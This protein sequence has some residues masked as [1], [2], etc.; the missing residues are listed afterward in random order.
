MGSQEPV[1]GHQER[2]DLDDRLDAVTAQ[3]EPGVERPREQLIW[4][5]AI[6][7]RACRTMG[8][9]LYTNLL[10]RALADLED[11]GPTWR[12]VRP[13]VAPGRGHAIALRLLAAVHRLVL[14]SEAPHLEPFYASAGGQADPTAAWPAV[15]ALLEDREHDLAPLVALACQTND[16]GRASLLAIG[17]LD[18]A[19]RTGQPIALTEIGTAAGLNLRWDRFH[20]AGGGQRWGDPD[21][22]GDL[23]GFWVDVPAIGDVQATVISRR[24]VDRSPID[25]TTEEGELALTSSVWG[26]QAARF[27]RLRGAIDLA[28]TEPA[29]LVTADAVGWV[30]NNLAPI[31]GQ[32]T[33]LAQS[34]LRE[35]LDADS[36]RR[37]DAAVAAAGARATVTAPLAWVQL[38]PID[39]QRRHGLRVTLWPGGETR[40][41]TTAGSF[42]TDVRRV[43]AGAA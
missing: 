31:D 23:T 29:E 4:Q 16:P 1:V 12:L 43:D 3:P 6:Q 27:E 24:G 28:R 35:Y 38:E 41:L 37:L 19:A 5:F 10:T 22:P 21:R 14:T 9:E 34:V 13:H 32:T 33:V 2:D 11:Q 30:E 36:R 17:F 15:R 42:G 25:A 8:S 18:V 39:Q 26:D 40:A 20:Y 7:A